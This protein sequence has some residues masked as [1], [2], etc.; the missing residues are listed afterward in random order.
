MLK[1]FDRNLSYIPE[2]VRTTAVPVLAA[3]ASISVGAS[4]AVVG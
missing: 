4:A 2:P 3:K 1:E